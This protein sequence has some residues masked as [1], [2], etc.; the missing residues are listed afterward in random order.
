MSVGTVLVILA[1]HVG[2]SAPM[3][4]ARKYNGVAVLWE[5]RF[6]GESQ[7]FEVDNATGFATDGYSAYQYLTNEQALEDTVY[8][9]QNFRPGILRQNWK[10][11]SPHKTPWVF[12]GGSYPGTSSV[13]GGPEQY[14]API[15]LCPTKRHCRHRK[16]AGFRLWPDTLYP[17]T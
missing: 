16:A 5:H 4:L 11:L 7:P 15:I 10:A 17:T 14:P 9:A 3:A 8:F 12:I 6:Y 1:E 2:P 13:P